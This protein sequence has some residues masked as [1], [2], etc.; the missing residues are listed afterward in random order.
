MEIYN[1][2]DDFTG[3][4]SLSKGNQLK[5]HLDNLWYKA[6]FLG[7]EG[8]S[9]VVC[10][11][12]L[13]YT[14]IKDYVY[15]D[16]E[17]MSFN[18]KTYNGCKS[19]HFLNKYEEIVTIDKLH[20]QYVNKPISLMLEGKS[21]KDKIKYTVDFVKNITGIS[22][23][24]QLLT[25]MLEWDSFV[26]NEDRHFNNIAV[27]YNNNTKQYKFCPIFDNGAA[28][29]SDIREE[30]PLEKSIYGL[31]SKVKAK[32][33]YEDFEKQV[34]ACEDIYG[35]QLKID[36]SIHLSEDLKNQIKYNYGNKVFNRITQV[37]DNQIYLSDYICSYFKEPIKKE[38]SL[39]VYHDIE[40][41][42][43]EL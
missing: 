9:E 22:N 10:S 26:L 32:P 36:K 25:Q 28:F 11:E 41:N 16:L 29:L 4:I 19:K 6:D 15:Y 24:G 13:A 7:Y 43:I 17:K 37:L 35:V 27:I 3:K 1:S 18:D 39:S 21:V 23:F 14:N 34:K 20:K 31:I 5:I 42:D 8:A 12:L 38:D 2:F 40:E 33:F 30:Y